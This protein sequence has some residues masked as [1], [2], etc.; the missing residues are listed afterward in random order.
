MRCDVCARAPP[1]GTAEGERWICKPSGMNQGKGIFLVQSSSQLREVL[2]ND[3]AKATP[4][5][6]PP[7]RVI[8]R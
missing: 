6:R 2:H 4:T 8:Q 3:E 5:K 7:V 1:L